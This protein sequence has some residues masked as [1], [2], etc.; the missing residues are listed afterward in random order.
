DRL[1]L[2]RDSEKIGAALAAELT[3]AIEDATS[4]VGTRVVEGAVEAVDSLRAAGIPTA[5][6]C[7]TGFTPAR[8]VRRFLDQHGLKLDHYFF[9][10]LVG[11]PKPLPPMFQ[12]ALT[13]TASPPERAIHIG[14]L[15]STDIAGARAAG[16]ATIRF[17][18][19]H[20]DAWAEEESRGEEADEVLGAWQDLPS[21]LGL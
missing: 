3:A 12:A 6:I 1:G 16:M 11:A 20:D 13:A 4:E 21:L 5:L 14:D 2:G 9:S 7:D 8:H 18:G 10:E 15:K 19:V 17:I